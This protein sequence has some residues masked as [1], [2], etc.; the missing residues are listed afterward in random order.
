MKLEHPDAFASVDPAGSVV[1]AFVDGTVSGGPQGQQTL[2]VAVNGVVQAVA[3]TYV[4]DGETRFGAIV[5]A[6]AFRR[7]RND[8]KLFAITGTGDGRRFSQLHS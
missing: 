1:P 5:P 4:A 8:V 2:A 3:Q 6:A 7:G